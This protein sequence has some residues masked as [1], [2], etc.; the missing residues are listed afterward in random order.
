MDLSREHG[1]V[2]RRG[3]GQAWAG[4]GLALLS[5]VMLAGASVGWL[6]GD[7]AVVGER[8][9]LGAESGVAP[10]LASLLG[11]YKGLLDLWPLPL[12]LW[13]ALRRDAATAALVWAVAVVV[14]PLAD[15]AAHAMTGRAWADAVVHI[16][17]LAAMTG[18]AAAYA[19]AAR[20]PDRAM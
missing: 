17:F 11:F 9:G 6:A 12:A 20:R 19:I 16:P 4:H 15:I 14:I 13:A 7:P 1:V 10:A 2:A 5:A 3:G 18:A 8:T